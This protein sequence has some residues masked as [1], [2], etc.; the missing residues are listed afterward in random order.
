LAQQ[1]QPGNWLLVTGETNAK[2]KSQ[3][4]KLSSCRLAATTSL[5][6]QFDIA[7]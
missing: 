7:L 5:I 3:K 4:S 2:I 1:S 6:L